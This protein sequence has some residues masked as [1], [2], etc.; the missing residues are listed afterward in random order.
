L[1]LFEECA[2]HAEGDFE[3]GIFLDEP[4]KHFCGRQIAFV[5]DL[6]EYLFVHLVPDELFPCGV[7]PERLVQLKIKCRYWHL[8]PFFD[9]NRNL[10]PANNSLRTQPN[11]FNQTIYTARSHY[12]PL[13]Q[14][15]AKELGLRGDFVKMGKLKEANSSRYFFA[16]LSDA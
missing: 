7:Q 16:V 10:G 14:K 3:I 11:R 13:L 15:N 4:G 8:L 9:I 1:R 5:G 6:F 12:K 2:G